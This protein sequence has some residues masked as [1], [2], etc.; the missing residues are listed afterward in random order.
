MS[1]R[2]YY[3]VLGVSK[4]ADISEIKKAYR[5]LVNK[6]HPDKNNDKSESEKKVVEQQ[7]KE[8]QEAYEILSDSE[9][10]S[11]YD[12]YGHQAFE[13]GF[14]QGY[15]QGFGGF[16][17]IFSDIFSGFGFGSS[18]SRQNYPTQGDDLSASIKIDFVDSILGT[19][20]SQKFNKYEKCGHCDGTGA[21]SPNDIQVCGQCAGSGSVVENVSI[22]GFGRVQNKSVCR[23]CSGRGKVIAHKCRTCSGQTFVK[24]IKEM[25]IEIPAGIKDGTKIRLSGFGEPGSNGGENGDLYILIRVKEH[26][27]YTRANNDIHINLPVSVIDVIS[28][29]VVEVPSPTGMKNLKL[30]DSSRSGDILTI[31]GAGAPDPRN[32]RIVGDLKVHLAFYVPEFNN[33]QKAKLQEIFSEVNDKV[34][35]KWLKDF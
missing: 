1:K 22:P 23:R 29:N 32:P 25:N 33:K 19:S 20:F 34:K 15:S 16:S 7:F 5:V 30:R 2:D 10:R 6:Y 21:D 14:G 4:T 28:E 31:T 24:T 18:R 17:D 12:Q 11:Q 27:Y 13:Q 3:Q 35:S 9:K 8:V 26:K